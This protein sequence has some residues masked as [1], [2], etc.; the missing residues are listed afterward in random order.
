M[1]TRFEGPRTADLRWVVVPATLGSAVIHAAVMGPHF[2]ESPV[3]GVAFAVMVVALGLS[4]IEAAVRPGRRQL[5]AVAA[6]H[7]VILGLWAWTRTVG[8]P[9]QGVEGVAFTDAAAVLLG[10]VGLG[11]ALAGLSR[12]V[13]RSARS[14]RRPIAAAGVAVLAVAALTVPAVAEADD[15][16]HATSGAHGTTADG[17]H[18]ADMTGT[19]AAH[20]HGAEAGAT[21]DTAGAGAASI[22]MASISA[23]FSTVDH[24]HHEGGTGNARFHD[25]SS[26]PCVPTAEQVQAADDII[27]AVTF[28]IERYRDPEVAVADGYRPLGFE[29]N[30]I[31]HYLHAGYR[32]DDAHL[33]PTR[34][35]ALLYGRTP[36][37]G[38]IPVGVMFMMDQP[39]QAG[40]RIGGCLTP[41]HAHGYPFAPRGEESAEMMH[42]WTIPVPGG[43]FAEHI[44]GEYARL[45]L[46]KEA[47]DA[48]RALNERLPAEPGTTTTSR[49]DQMLTIQQRLNAI[50]VHREVLCSPGVRPGL[51]RRWTTPGLIERLCDPT[52]NGLLPGVEAVPLAELAAAFG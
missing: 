18:D 50:N 32:T 45:Y 36:D 30:G 34:P 9:G 11:G 20:D 15:H 16:V 28:A 41:W 43:P 48:D 39:G 5:V 49:T 3:E 10:A 14:G 19:D 7:A 2:E 25:A 24:A 22:D 26:E 40:E 37:G 27:A 21:I 29:P 47:I 1:D 17:A 52:M 8:L 4:A 38:L 31:H 46:G 35:E 23:I 13:D 42:V 33:D 6:V 44:E 12:L 51:E